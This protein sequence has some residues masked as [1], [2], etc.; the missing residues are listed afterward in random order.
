[1]STRRLHRLSL[2]VAALLL[3][4]FPCVDYV[5]NSDDIINYWQLMNRQ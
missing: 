4:F 5:V 3:T 1:M 2:G